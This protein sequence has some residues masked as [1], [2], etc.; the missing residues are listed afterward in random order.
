[1]VSVPSVST[2]KTDSDQAEGSASPR[3]D[4]AGRDRAALRAGHHR[5][6]V[7]VVPHVERARRAAA[8]GDREDGDQRGQR[9]DM[10]RRHHHAD[11]GREHDQRHD[12]RLEKREIIPGQR[13]GDA[14][15]VA[16]DVFD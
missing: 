11:K 3:Q 6:D 9:I 7:G 12:A 2:A 4:L 10:A 16:L 13:L 14:C 1:L 8:D 5:V 15:L